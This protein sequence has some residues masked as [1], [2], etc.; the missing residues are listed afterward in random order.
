LLPD[1]ASRDEQISRFRIAVN[2][3]SSLLLKIFGFGP[4]AAR[5][6][7]VVI[8]A[9]KFGLSTP[10]LR[11]RTACASSLLIVHDSCNSPHPC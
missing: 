3:K 7:E 8:F 10:P 9:D 2:G 5:S 11:A 6:S 4:G 1:P